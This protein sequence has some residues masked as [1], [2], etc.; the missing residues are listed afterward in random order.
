MSFYLRGNKIT[1]SAA[2]M[3]FYRN[4][5]NQGAMLEEINEAWQA[6]KQSEDAR[7]CYLPSELEIIA[8]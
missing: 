4:Q 6:C 1:E 8:A 3:F 7:D 5:I 2:W